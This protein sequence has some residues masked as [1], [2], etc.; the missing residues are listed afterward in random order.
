[1]KNRFLGVVSLL[2]LSVSG[3]IAAPAVE[4]PNITAQSSHPKYQPFIAVDGRFDRSFV[5]WLSEPF[6][7]GTKQS[8]KDVWWELEMPHKFRVQGVKIIGDER[9][10]GSMP[11]NFRIE[12]LDGKTWKTAAEAHDVKTT[13][14]T[15]TWPQPVETTSLR[16][17][18]PANDVPGIV[19]IVEFVPILPGGEEKTVPA[20][21]GLSPTQASIPSP[22]P[23]FPS[24]TAAGLPVF[25][26]HGVVLDYEGLKYRPHDDVIFP[27]VIRTDKL[28]HP[29][30]RYYMYYA[31]HDAPGG[32]CLAYADS[33]EGP[34]KEYA[35]NPIITNKWEPYYKVSHVS[36]PHALWMEDEGKLFVYYHGENS[37]TRFASST[38]GIHFTYEDVAFKTDMF[39]DL[40]EASYARIFRYTIPGTDIRYIALVM[41][42]NK[43]T[44]RIYMATSKD[45]RTWEARQEALVD[46]PAGTDQVSGIW[47][48]PWKGKNYLVYHAHWTVQQMVVDLHA[49]EVDPAF[50]KAKYVGLLYD[51]KEAGLD[52]VAQMSPCMIEENGKLYLFV[53]IG[54]RLNQKIS[55][56][57][58]PADTKQ[59]SN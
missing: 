31:P 56:A 6:G 27:S 18:V 40:S 59:T 44:R 13:T 15:V 43:G 28:Q 36:G 42:N 16:F 51:H 45:G 48:M 9:G 55:L 30:G 53:N 52:N 21:L 58:A 34:W 37:V 4:W 26:Y 12:W 24:A 8:P 10:L 3:L 2:V 29:L 17:F 54:P 20:I 5:A 22:G 23:T 49:S 38:D 47:F 41:G 39:H 1:M 35:Q 32:I 11:K 50:T 25:K 14:V 46:P 57:I 19:R 33:L 7:G